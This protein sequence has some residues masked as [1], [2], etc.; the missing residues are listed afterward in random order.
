MSKETLVV[1]GIKRTLE[2]LED[3]SETLTDTGP[4]T[5]L[6]QKIKAAIEIATYIVEGE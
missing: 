1:E 3:I 6:T 4:N 2:G 5:E